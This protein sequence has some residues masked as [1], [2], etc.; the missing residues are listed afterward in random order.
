MSIFTEE[1]FD[2]QEAESRRWR[3]VRCVKS[4]WKIRPGAVG[5]V[6]RGATPDGKHW[7]VVVYWEGQIEGY[8]SKTAYETVCEEIEQQRGAGTDARG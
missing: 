3:K 5:E 1:C 8:L 6:T 7:Y 4:W 2:Q